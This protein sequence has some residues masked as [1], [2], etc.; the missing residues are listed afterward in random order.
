MT[1]VPALK[2]LIDGHLD[3]QML[4]ELSLVLMFCEQGG[5]MPNTSQAKDLFNTI[6]SQ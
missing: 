6:C 3:K 5:D 1:N 4:K 2:Q